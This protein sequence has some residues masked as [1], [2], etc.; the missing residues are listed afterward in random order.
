M[1]F[2]IPED[3]SALTLSNIKNTVGADPTRQPSFFEHPWYAGEA[4]M[5]TPC[6]SGW[7]LIYMDVLS[8]SVGQAWDYPLPHGFALPHAVE[9]VLMLFLHYARSTEQLL[10]R[11]H[12]WCIDP[13]SGGRRVT[14][15]AF[16]RNGVFVSAHPP[17]F[18]SRGLGVC[19]RVVV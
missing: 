11:K 8:E 6:P 19:P 14:V 3:N 18:G 4:F 15:G 13:A 17:G 7:R 10:S 2:P 12:T 1:G 9:V 16:G 5:D